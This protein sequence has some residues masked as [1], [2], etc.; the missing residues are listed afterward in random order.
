MIYQLTITVLLKKDLHFRQS[1][2]KISE[3]INKSFLG[4]KVMKNK[5]ERNEYKYYVFDNLYPRSKYKYYRKNRI[6]IF[7]I[8]TS[9]EVMYNSMYNLLNSIE[10]DFFA[11]ISISKKELHI[12]KIKE[13]MTVT[14]AVMTIEGSY[15]TLDNGLEELERGINN[16]LLKKYKQLYGKEDLKKDSFFYDIEILNNKPIGIKYKGISFLG[17]KMRLKIK[18]D[19]DS[20]KLAKLAI[21]AGILEKNSSC[22]MGYCTYKEI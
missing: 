19:E 4:D 12:A 14:P 7:N 22:G 1:S 8:R 15:W 16:N 17:H 9:I 11:T 10:T 5:H 2:Y 6:Y 20:Q 18:E 21:S 3:L 13:I